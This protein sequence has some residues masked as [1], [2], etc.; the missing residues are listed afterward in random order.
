[1]NIDLKKITEILKSFEEIEFAYLFGSLAEGNV[2]C[3]SDIDLGIYVDKSVDLYDFD[4]YPFGYEAYITG[5][6]NLLLKTDLVDLIVLN[7]ANLLISEKIYNTGK[8]LLEKDR[9]LRVR[10]ENGV[11]KEFIDT[12]Y[13]RRIKSKYLKS[14]LNVR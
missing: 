12:Q 4:K 2:N 14:Y 5:R 7:N 3:K 1:M 13:F 11:R 10:I 9:L 8:L 6:L